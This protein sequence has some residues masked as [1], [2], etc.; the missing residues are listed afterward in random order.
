[1]YTSGVRAPLLRVVII[2]ATGG[3]SACSGTG[4]APPLVDAAPILTGDIRA[5]SSVGL[6]LPFQEV[7][8]RFG[9]S[10]APSSPSTSAR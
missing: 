1:M 7:G 9:D 3:V 6:Q 2:V 10:A 8:A 5:A 4:T